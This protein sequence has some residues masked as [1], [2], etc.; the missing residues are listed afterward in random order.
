MLHIVYAPLA[1]QVKGSHGVHFISEK[2]NA[3]R[4]FHARAKHVQN[5]AA[6]R[7]LPHTFHLL[8]TGITQTDQPL[9]QR[10]Q[11]HRIGQMQRQRII[12]QRLFGQR[13]LYQRLRRSDH[14]V[15]LL[16]CHAVKRF[17][18]PLLPFAGSR[19]RRV[20][21]EFPP[22]QQQRRNAG[23][24][25]QIRRHTARLSLVAA[26]HQKGA[27]LL[28][29]Q[30]RADMGAV[31]RPQARH[32]GRTASVFRAVQQLCRLRDLSQCPD[33]LLH[34]FLLPLHN[35]QRQSTL[36]RGGG[37]RTARMVSF[38]LLY[39]MLLQLKRLMAAAQPS[40]ITHSAASRPRRI[41]SSSIFH[42]AAVGR[43]ST[44]AARS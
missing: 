35:R 7:K 9:A 24:I 22:R 25:L 19:R 28:R 43:P 34:E 30:C 4:R 15:G 2:F 5:A 40:E 16:L 39:V 41:V 38:S 29:Q 14:N 18:P 27:L 1:C 21:L 36:P 23:E 20:E 33:Q 3:Y 26:Y 11:V 32:G 8:A 44:Q 12:Q 13:P 10:V 17:H 6:Q 42:S 31:N 37:A